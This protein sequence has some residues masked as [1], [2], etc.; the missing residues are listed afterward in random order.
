MTSLCKS[1]S[2]ALLRAT[3]NFTRDHLG[4]PKL[5]LPLFNRRWVA[6]SCNAHASPRPPFPAKFV[7]VDQCIPFVQS[8]PA[9]LPT[10]YRCRHQ[11]SCHQHLVSALPTISLA[12]PLTLI[13]LHSDRYSHSYV[14]K[15]ADKV[16]GGMLTSC[17]RANVFWHKKGWQPNS[18]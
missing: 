12:Y 10:P 2:L 11:C 7:W 9:H 6:D 16:V 17:S 5:P 18:D 15:C 13:E 1:D 8:L 3:A 4:K 14:S